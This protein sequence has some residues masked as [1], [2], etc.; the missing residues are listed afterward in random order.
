MRPR[1]LAVSVALGIVGAAAFLAE[2]FIGPA[3][4]TP[5]QVWAAVIG[6]GTKVETAIVWQL[7]VPRALLAMAVGGGL[8]VVGVAMQ[9]LVR[10]PLAEP[11]VLGASGGAS[12]GAALF[13]LGFVPPVVAKAVSMSVAAVIGSWLALAFVF[14]VAR[15][16]PRL[17]TAR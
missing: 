15:Q 3:D 7:R 10:N 11:Y 8:A 12:A 14:L 16:G 5:S 9:A 13:Y 2:V 17:S 4:L 6:Q 1:T